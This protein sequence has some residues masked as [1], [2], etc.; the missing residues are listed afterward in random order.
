MGAILGMPLPLTA[1]PKGVIRVDNG[2]INFV[3]LKSRNAKTGV[4]SHLTR[5]CNNQCKQLYVWHYLWQQPQKGITKLTFIYLKAPMVYPM[6][7][8][9]L[10][11]L[12]YGMPN[13]SNFKCEFA[14]NRN[15][16]SGMKK[17]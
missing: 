2:D 12:E 17:G 9:S 15:H 4:T 13:A 1:L 7:Y 14:H 8:R 10:V 16:K 11:F 5:I 6:P 3:L